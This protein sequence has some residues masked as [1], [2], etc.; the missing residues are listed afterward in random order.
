MIVEVLDLFEVLQTADI[1]RIAEKLIEA[2]KTNVKF[3]N[4]ERGRFDP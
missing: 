2:A 3:V 1:D 4:P